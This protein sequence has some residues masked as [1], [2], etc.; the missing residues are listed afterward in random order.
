MIPIDFFFCSRFNDALRSTAFIIACNDD[1]V[2]E[3]RIWNA[4]FMISLKVLC[5]C[6]PEKTD[7]NPG[8]YQS[9]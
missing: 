8:K 2:E 9:G 6:S 5:R 3:V 4:A 1:I 7:E